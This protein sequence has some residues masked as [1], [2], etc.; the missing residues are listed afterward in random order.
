VSV[1][2]VDRRSL[3]AT[4]GGGRIFGDLGPPSYPAF[5]GFDGWTFSPADCRFDYQHNPPLHRRGHAALS[6]HVDETST[7]LVVREYDVDEQT[8]T[9]VAGVGLRRLYLTVASLGGYPPVGRSHARPA[10]DRL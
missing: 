10:D 2:D 6:T 3:D 8:H 4:T 7:E 1:D 9:P 5:T